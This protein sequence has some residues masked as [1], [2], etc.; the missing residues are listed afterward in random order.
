MDTK[1]AKARVEAEAAKVGMEQVEQVLAY[2]TD[3]AET[4]HKSAID[5]LVRLAKQITTFYALVNDWYHGR[6]V[7][8][9]RTIAM[10]VAAFLYFINPLDIVPDVIPAIG[11]LD[12]ATLVALTVRACQADLE[13]YCRARSIPFEEAGLA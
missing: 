7:C 4:L 11:Y 6:F 5:T 2:G 8:P 12:D 3:K 1:G 10:A 9:W 13:N